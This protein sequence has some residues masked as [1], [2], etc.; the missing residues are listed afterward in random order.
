MTRWTAGALLG[1]A[2]VALADDFQ[3]VAHPSVSGT[4]ISRA[5][6]AGIFTGRVQSWG[7]KSTARPVDQSA[8]APVRQAFAVTVIGLSMGELQ[9]YWHRKVAAERTF[10]PPV[11][12]SD[13]EVIAYVTSQPGAIGY[14]SAGT[15]IPPGLKVIAVGP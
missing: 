3:V 12:D 4:T 2:S 5:A 1:W 15:A 9:L 14:V 10:P 6:L 11:K 13:Q 8:R 7:D